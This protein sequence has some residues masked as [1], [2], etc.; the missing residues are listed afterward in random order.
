MYYKNVVVSQQKFVYQLLQKCSSVKVKPMIHYYKNVV[1]TA[2]NILQKCSS[3]YFIKPLDR[4]R[5]EW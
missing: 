5:I 2:T 3:R 4:L 1:R